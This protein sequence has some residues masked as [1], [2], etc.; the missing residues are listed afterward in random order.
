[1]EYHRTSYQRE[2]KPSHVTPMA[3]KIYRNILKEKHGSKDPFETT[4]AN[5]SMETHWKKL[6]LA[7]QILPIPGCWLPDP[8]TK[9]AHA[10]RP[11]NKIWVS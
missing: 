10:P 1:M 7:P 11:L 6:Y 3:G 4:Q 8:Q 2:T 5:F 9:S